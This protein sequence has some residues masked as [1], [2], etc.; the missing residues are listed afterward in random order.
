MSMEMEK[1]IGSYF[2]KK[3][4]INFLYIFTVF[5]ILF[6]GLPSTYA[7]SS[8]YLQLPQFS[9]TRRH[10]LQAVKDCQLDVQSW[11]YTIVTSKCKGPKYP[12]KPCCEAFKDLACPNAKD[13][14][15]LSNN[16]A[17][18]MF[19]YIN[20]YG[21]YPP[22]LFANICRDSRRGLECTA[23]QKSNQVNRA[24]STTSA[25]ATTIPTTIP[26]MFAFLTVLCSMFL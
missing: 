5:F 7:S 10:L 14:N 15:D 3:N 8:D 11:N 12:A 17:T 9:S 6:I 2:P 21:K 4:L 1:H 16:C 25:A 20:L 19:S 23:A 13:L 24:T 22:G 18:T 26:L